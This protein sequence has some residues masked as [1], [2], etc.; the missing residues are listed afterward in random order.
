MPTSMRTDEVYPF[1]NDGLGW[2]PECD[3]EWSDADRHHPDFE[4]SDIDLAGTYMAPAW[5]DAA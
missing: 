5:T 2:C 3:A 1:D 4:P